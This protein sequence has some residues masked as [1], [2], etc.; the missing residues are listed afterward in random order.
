MGIDV[1]GSEEECRNHWQAFLPYRKLLQEYHLS[2]Q[3]NIVD[4]TD[5][6]LLLHIVQ[7]LDLQRLFDTYEIFQSKETIQDIL[8]KY[9]V[10]LV[11]CPTSSN[12]KKIDTQANH[13]ESTSD[14]DATSV[15][16]NTFIHY[17][18]SQYVNYSI[19]SVS[20]TEYQQSLVQI[21][22][23]LL[24]SNLH[25]L[26]CEHVSFEFSRKYLSSRVFRST[27]RCIG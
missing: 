14:N 9:A 12:Y 16:S 11:V 5:Q 20:P 6:E 18:L 10:H 17:L 24:H 21:Y 25:R 27:I 3:A 13:V 19:S 7:G 15:L 4:C 22:H 8:I 2:W 26:T 1:Y 23:D